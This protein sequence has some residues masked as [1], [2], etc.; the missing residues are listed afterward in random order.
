[1]ASQKRFLVFG[2]HPDDP[3]IQFGG[4]ALMLAKAGHLV[5]FVS[6]TNGECGHHRMNPL[7]SSPDVMPRL[8]LRQR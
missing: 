4:A 2:A 1:M 5:K 7:N 8:R 3:D 6:V